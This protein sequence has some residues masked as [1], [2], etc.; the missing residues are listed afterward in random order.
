MTGGAGAGFGASMVVGQYR[1]LVDGGRDC[2]GPLRLQVDED[3]RRGR[4]LGQ[5]HLRLPDTRRLRELKD[6]TA[7][8][9]AAC[10]MRIAL[11]RPCPAGGSPAGQAESGVFQRNDDLPGIRLRLDSIFW[12][13]ALRSRTTRVLSGCTPSRMFTTST[14][15]D[16]MADKQAPATRQEASEIPVGCGDPAALLVDIYRTRYCC[17][18]R[19]L[20]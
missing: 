18:Y 16:A 4:S 1:I 11:I 17:L 12:R 3:A 19:N 2:I 9:P 14:A 10:S 15:A 20:P 6:H 5:Q 7:P 8:P 13:E